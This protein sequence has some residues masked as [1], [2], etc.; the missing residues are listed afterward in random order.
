MYRQLATAAAESNAQQKN[1]SNGGNKMHD[2]VNNGLKSLRI[3]MALNTVKSVVG[4]LFPLI[5]FPYISRVLGVENIGRYNFSRSVINYFIMIAGLGINSYAIREG[6]KLR[7][8]PVRLKRLADEVFSI[9][10]LSTAA[11]YGLLGIFLVFVPKFRGYMDLLLVLSLQ[12]LFQTI[13]IEWMYSIY[14]D[15]MYI[16]VRTVF[17]QFISLSTMFLLV[18]SENDTATYAAVTVISAA[19]ANILNFMHARKRCR[20]KLTL[21]IDWKKHLKPVLVLFATSAMIYVYVNS[22][23]TI[24]GFLCDDKTVGIYSVATKAYSIIKT[25]LSS[26]IVVSIPRLASLLGKDNLDEFCAVS[27]NI[28]RTMLT[29]LF[30]VVTG[31]MLLRKPI[32]FLF[33]GES[34]E[35][36]SSSLFLLCIALICC[37]GAYFWG[38]C[39]IV[40]VGLENVLFRAT[41]VSALINI[42]LNFILIPFWKENAAAFT[43]IMAEGI[44]FLW[45]AWEG[46]KHVQMKG[47]ITFLG[48]ILAGC[49]SLVVVDVTVSR[50]V[51]NVVAHIVLTIVFSVL[52]Y[53]VVEIMLHNEIVLDI[54]NGLLPVKSQTK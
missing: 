49:L 10:M 32:I 46:K 50:M 30:P 53:G 6:A 1:E 39:V 43:T 31:I 19:G 33:A 52:G 23:I 18:R 28:Y 26:I 40:P 51:S 7:N 14:E 24:L 5:T 17:F 41:V 35:S 13:G 12:I 20:I 9:N 22:D 3:N 16:T 38:Q 36:A 47:T 44:V 34:Y 37:F 21:H 8:D 11:A 25:I 48:K 4:L 42:V 2:K 27:Q 45:C 29:F 15:Y 54:A